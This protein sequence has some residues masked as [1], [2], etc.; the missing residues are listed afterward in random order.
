[1]NT[2]DNTR[3]EAMGVQLEALEAKREMA[4]REANALISEAIEAIY[5]WRDERDEVLRDI[6]EVLEEQEEEYYAE[7][8][9]GEIDDI[10][11]LDGGP[12][13]KTL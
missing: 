1:M 10:Y 3:I 6:P 8:L 12:P 4:V 9:V 2:P 5:E 7:D 13:Q 11:L